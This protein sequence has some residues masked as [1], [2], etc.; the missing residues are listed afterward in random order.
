MIDHALAISPLG[1]LLFHLK[2]GFWLY[3]WPMMIGFLTILGYQSLG[4]VTMMGTAKWLTVFG[5][6]SV[7][8]M[9]SLFGWMLMVRRV[10][11]IPFYGC[12]V[13]LAS[14]MMSRVYAVTMPVHPR[15]KIRIIRVTWR[16][17]AKGIEQ[18]Q[19]GLRARAAAGV[20][21][22]VAKV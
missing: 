17:D 6:A 22:A 18:L 13:G 4:R 3:A 11:M 12:G 1:A 15:L 8:S 2:E 19:Q 10:E 20:E 9:M 14:A 7:V 21:T 16:G 5:L